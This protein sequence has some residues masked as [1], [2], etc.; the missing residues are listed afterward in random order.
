MLTPEEKNVL[1]DALR[2][3]PTQLEALVIDLTDSQLET[4]FLNG[5][6]TVAQNVHHVADSHMNAYIRTKLLLTKDHP[7]LNAYDQDVWANLPDVH[8]TR[9]E[10]SLSIIRGLHARWVALYE[11]LTDDQF[12][13]TGLHP[14]NGVVSVEGLIRTYA[15]HS[16]AHLDQITR[17]LAA[18]NM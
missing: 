12:A 7:T 14:D 6:W 15:D 8:A 5:E 18:Q 11:S 9:I 17:T 13:R 1:I 16:R 2:T 3:F 10:L 4:A